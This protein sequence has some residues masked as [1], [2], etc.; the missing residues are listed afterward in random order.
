MSMLYSRIF[1]SLIARDVLINYFNLVL[2]R[3]IPWFPSINRPALVAD[4]ANYNS[5]NNRF[6]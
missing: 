3:V 2:T 5:K 4:P 6:R 1:Q